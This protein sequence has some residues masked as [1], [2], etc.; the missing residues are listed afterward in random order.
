MLC[1]IYD[2]YLENIYISEIGIGSMLNGEKIQLK[3]RNE[4]NKLTVG[5]M[6]RDI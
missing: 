1:V 2:S 4:I 3:S 6:Y 5:W